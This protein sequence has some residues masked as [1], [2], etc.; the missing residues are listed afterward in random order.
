MIDDNY[1]DKLLKIKTSG[2]DD[3]DADLKKF[4]YEPTPYSILERLANTGYINKKSVLLDYGCGKGRVSIYMTHQTRC[5]S[6]GIDYN[7][8]LL[9]KALDNIKNF[10]AKNKISFINANASDFIL[11]NNINCCY[12]F[13]PFSI[14]IL[15]DVINRIYN[16][17]VSFNRDILLFFYYPSNKYIEYLNN[18]AFIKKIDEID[19]SDIFFNDEKEKILIYIIKEDMKS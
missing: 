5:K 11:P 1:F 3:I 12:F 15:N 13:N 8:R 4:P 18:K 10:K 14:E 6:I 2:R 17:Y 16:S 7:E 9:N 19:C